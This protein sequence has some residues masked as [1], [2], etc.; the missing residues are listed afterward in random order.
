MQY[1]VEQSGNLSW[2][3]FRAMMKKSGEIL[4]LWLLFEGWTSELNF[5]QVLMRSDGEA[6]AVN[7]PDLDPV[8]TP[9]GVR[10]VD[11][12]HA[13]L[14]ENHHHHGHDHSHA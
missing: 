8:E 10:W 11:P 5:F 1:K 9:E 13:N 7:L 3:D 4:A 6:V 12:T 2:T 14:P